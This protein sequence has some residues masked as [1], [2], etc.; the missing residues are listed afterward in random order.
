[1]FLDRRAEPRSPAW[2]SPKWVL[3]GFFLSNL[4]AFIFPLLVPLLLES[5]LTPRQSAITQSLALLF[6]AALAPF[7][8]RLLDQ[9]REV[10]VFTA[11]G[12]CILGGGTALLFPGHQH[13]TIAISLSC[14]FVVGVAVMNLAAKRLTEGL[15]NREH[16]S[17]AASWTYMV[18]NAAGLG[19]AG[20]AFLLIQSYK[21]EL[22]LIDI[23]SSLVFLFFLLRMYRVAFS[24]TPQPAT[25]TGLHDRLEHLRSH[26]RIWI[27][28]TPLLL[29]AFCHISA[30][31]L[32][33]DAANLD[34]KKMMALLL[35]GNTS[36]VVLISLLKNRFLHLSV[37]TEAILAVVFLSLGKAMLPF[38]LTTPGIFLTTVIWSVGEAFT[39]P[40][41]SK[42]IIQQFPHSKA[43]L[44]VGVRDLVLRGTLVASPLLT[45]ALPLSNPIFFAW[46]YGLLP[47]VSLPLL[48]FYTRNTSG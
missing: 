8:G 17:S 7:A 42:L 28:C 35:I 4:L 19:S 38:L 40:L 39:Y 32:L 48:F 36:T 37:T 25:T 24:P 11:S 21:F 3:F 2:V 18:E 16:L 10:L 22:I 1:M 27:L 33:Y 9:K 6:S 46:F 30:V 34:S 23:L 29:T 45:I 43:G 44:A 26:R 14:A 13:F 5:G 47:L 12:L 20:I 41:L 31:P 15:A